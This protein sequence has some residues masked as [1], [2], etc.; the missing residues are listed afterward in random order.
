M[1]IDWGCPEVEVVNR[2]IWFE[3]VEE[4]MVMVS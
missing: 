2:R 3:G 1:L 4:E